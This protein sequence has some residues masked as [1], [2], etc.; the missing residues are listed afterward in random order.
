MH[1]LAVRLE[2]E[3]MK[4]AVS[5]IGILATLTGL[6]WIGQGTGYFPYPR[7]SFM[8]SQ[9]P[10]AYRGIALALVGLVAIVIARRMPPRR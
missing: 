9:T 7:S 5:V 2:G 1:K 3:V 6:V 10:W 8:I 4:T